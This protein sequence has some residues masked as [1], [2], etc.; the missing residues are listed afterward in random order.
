MFEKGNTLSKKQRNVYPLHVEKRVPIMAGL[1]RDQ[2]RKMGVEPSELWSIVGSDA[3]TTLVNRIN[4]G[5]LTLKD[6]VMIS[7]YL[8]VDWGAVIDECRIE[9]GSIEETE[10]PTLEPV[11]ETPEMHDFFSMF[12]NLNPDES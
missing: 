6:M 7:D 3:K 2:L 10:Q 12:P 9:R 4:S 8:P 11:E 5:K 1:I